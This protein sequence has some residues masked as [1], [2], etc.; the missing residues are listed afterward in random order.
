LV[1]EIEVKQTMAILGG[2]VSIDVVVSLV[3]E[4]KNLRVYSGTLAIDLKALTPRRTEATLLQA[5]Q[6]RNA[7]R[8][9]VILRAT[10]SFLK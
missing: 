6:M 10:A 4:M 8:Y 1:T 9:R 5:N 7:T 3:S 2:A